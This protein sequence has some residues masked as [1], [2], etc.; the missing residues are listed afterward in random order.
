MTSSARR[1][2]PII[3]SDGWVI[4]GAYRHKLGDLVL[5]AADV[6]VWLDLPIRIWLPRLARRTWR[7][8]RDRE[9]LWNGNTESIASAIWGRESLVVWAFRM[10]FRVAANGR[11]ASRTCRWSG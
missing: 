5:E 7:R 1:S 4:D 8:I 10:H 3:A 11:K 2:S 9:E 6:V